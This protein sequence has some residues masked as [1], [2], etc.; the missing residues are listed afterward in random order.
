MPT[1]SSSIETKAKK[2]ATNLTSKL[3]KDRDVKVAAYAKA[4]SVKPAEAEKKIPVLS[5]SMSKN[6]EDQKRTGRKQAEMVSR[7]ASWTCSGHHILDKARHVNLLKSGKYVSSPSS[8]FGKSETDVTTFDKFK[9]YWNAELKSQGL[10]NYARKAKYDGSD[11]YHV[12]LPD[13]RATVSETKV[14]A[15]LMEYANIAVLEGGKRNTSFESNKFW[16]SALKPHLE[17]AEKTKAKAETDRLAALQF[18]GKIAQKT[19]LFK[20]VNKSGPSSVM[21]LGDILPDTKEDIGKPKSKSIAL[22]YDFS[23]DSLARSIFEKVGLFETKGFDVMIRHQVNYNVVTYEALSQS[24][25][26]DLR[27]VCKLIYN[28]PVSKFLGLTLNA[29][30]KVELGKSAL[31]PKGAIILD[32]VLTTPIDKESGKVVFE[33]SGGSIKVK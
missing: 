11:A 27:V 9:S 22:A 21:K 24:F 12:E 19:S 23:Y 18:L 26:T 4:H 16:G 7:G 5:C 28:T 10:L 31:V 17:N 8:V 25:I 15:C 29:D 13:S 2:M 20:N 32:H 6:P 1:S 14:Q 30:V 33:I 3:K